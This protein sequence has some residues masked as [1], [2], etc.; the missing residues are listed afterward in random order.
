MKQQ[1]ELKSVRYGISFRP[2]TKSTVLFALATFSLVIQVVKS[3]SVH[4]DE[5]NDDIRNLGSATNGKLNFFPLLLPI[6]SF[7]KISN[8]TTLKAKVCD[9]FL[10]LL[11]HRTVEC[12]IEEKL[13]ANTITIF[14]QALITVKY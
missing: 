7:I 5:F 1:T 2:S 3:S 12:L 6:Y 14:Q 13:F 9:H 11:S 8:K 10:C 4:D